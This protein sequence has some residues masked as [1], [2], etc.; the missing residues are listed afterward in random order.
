M[1]AIRSYYVLEELA[2]SPELNDLVAAIKSERSRK[3]L[4]AE[5]RRGQPLEVVIPRA[6]YRLQLN[7]RFTFADAAA[8]VP[9]LAELGI[10]HCYTSPCFAARTGSSHGYDVVN[11]TEL[12]A[13]M[14]Y[15]F[16]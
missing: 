6:T 2:L 5:M 7:S 10:S 12:N 4:P 15:N 1:Y 11:P 13:E 3:V 8:M 16:V 14:S 9:Y